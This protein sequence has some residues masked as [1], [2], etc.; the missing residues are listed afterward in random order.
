MKKRERKYLN[1]KPGGLF[2]AVRNFD[3]LEPTERYVITPGII[4]M[5]DID[6]LIEQLNKCQRIK[7][8]I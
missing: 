1:K 4:S 7:K 5:K 6:E 8:N 2:N 3:S